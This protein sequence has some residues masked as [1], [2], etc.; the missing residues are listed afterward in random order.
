M[1]TH[2]RASIYY[3]SNLSNCTIIRHSIE[4]EAVV[5]ISSA[6]DQL[7]WLLF[8]DIL[9]NGDIGIS[10]TKH[11]YSVKWLTTVVQ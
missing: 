10:G 7:L 8:I 3:Q 1:S 9:L 4:A 2:V 6:Y 11:R 5:C